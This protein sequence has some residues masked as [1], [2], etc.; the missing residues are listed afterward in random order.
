MSDSERVHVDV[1]VALVSDDNH[2]VLVTFNDNWGMFTLPMTGRRRGA[3]GLEPRTR[4]A[5]RAAAEALGVPVRLVDEGPRRVLG[6]LQSGRQLVD[7]IYTYNVFHVEPHPDFT[8]GLQIRQPYLW[9]SPHLILA[10]VYEPISESTRFIVRSVLHVFEIPARLQHTSVLIIQRDDPDRGRQF[11][12]RWDPDWGYAVP[13]KR[14]EPPASTQPADLAAAALAGAER[15]IREELGLEPASD[16]TLARARSPEL[17]THGVSA[18]RGSPAFGVATQYIHSLFDAGL[19][20]PEKLR[21]EEALAWVTQEEIHQGWT[22][23]SHPAPDS[24]PVRAGRI[25][26]TVYEI[27]QGLGEIAEIE[28]PEVLEEIVDLSK[29][30]EARLRATSHGDEP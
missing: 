28:P 6:R 26:R 27:L 1:A 21:S 22:A 19:R 14:W 3:E 4:A 7:K 16:V 17:T 23:G 8:G 29:R 24:S 13:A 15:V 18:T 11:L 25:S 12:V 30:I 2:R 10:G 20:H 5:F 9:L